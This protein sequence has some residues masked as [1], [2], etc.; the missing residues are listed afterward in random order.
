MIQNGIQGHLKAH[1]IIT[2][3]EMKRND[4]K[5]PKDALKSTSYLLVFQEDARDDFYVNKKLPELQL[6]NYVEYPFL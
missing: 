6:N 1:N 3:L 4:P 2:S 5:N